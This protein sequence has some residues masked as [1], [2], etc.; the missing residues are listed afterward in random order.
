MHGAPR[1]ASYWRK[2]VDFLNR[3]IGSFFPRPEEATE[4]TSLPAY[5]LEHR[6]P[7]TTLLDPRKVDAIRYRRQILDWRDDFHLIL[8]K[9][10]IELAS[11]FAKFID[12]EL[13]DVSLFRRVMT[14]PASVMLKPSFDGRVRFKLANEAKLAAARLS[15]VLSKWE[16]T[17]Q[18]PRRVLRDFSDP[19]L[20]CIAST[21]FKPSNKDKILLEINSQVIRKIVSTYQ[22]QAATIALELIERGHT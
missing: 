10:E 1:L 12:G 5:P 4:V 16:M 13:N 20:T 7:E 19:N 6:L 11:S 2:L 14:K 8:C 21:G 22:N 18:L 15:E 17:S 3:D 9:S